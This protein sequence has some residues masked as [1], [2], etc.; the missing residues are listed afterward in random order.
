MNPNSVA[1]CLLSNGKFKNPNKEFTRDINRQLKEAWCSPSVDQNLCSE[2]SIDEMLSAIKTLKAGKAPGVDN[3]HPEFFLHMDDTC[4]DWLRQFFNHCLKM[5]SVPKIWK[6]SKVVAVL[7]PKKPPDNPS[8]YRPVS[9][10]CIPLK[11]YERLIYNR[12]QPITE[13]F[14]PNEQAGFR[15]GRSC[16]DQVALLTE[17]IE[18]AFDQK[19]KAGILCLW[20]SLQHMIQFG[21]GV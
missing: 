14:L 21:I 7:K 12:I 13:S 5:I 8:S 17:D 19:L 9:L 18:H 15:P 4:I 10:L 11:L 20:I 6:L 16:L 1:S 3:L 2:F